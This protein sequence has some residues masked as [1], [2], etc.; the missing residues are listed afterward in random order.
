M[1]CGAA[2]VNQLVGLNK[3]NPQ[4]LRLISDDFSLALAK[5]SNICGFQLLQCQNLLLFFSLLVVN[6]DLCF[7]FSLLVW[8]K[9]QF[10]DITLGS[11]KSALLFLY[12]SIS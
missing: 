2:T 9:K 3:M 6:E 8:V 12:F 10:E 1:S 5:L 11:E 4:L 7:S